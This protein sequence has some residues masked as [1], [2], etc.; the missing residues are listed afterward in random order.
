MLAR[1][2]KMFGSPQDVV[3]GF[4]DFEQKKHCKYKE[5]LKGKG[6]RTLFRK[7]GYEVYLV[8]EFCTSCR[9]SVCEGECSTFRECINPCFWRREKQPTVFRH[10]LVMCKTCSRVW[11][12]DTNGA[13]NMYK[14]MKE[15]IN[16]NG[17]PQYLSRTNSSISDATSVS[18]NQDLHGDAKPQPC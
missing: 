2:E 16:G 8:D 17:R 13:L 9:C 10:G 14:V 18:H 15:T 7:S 1:F 4:G 12:R 6:F 3:I 11:N 5:P